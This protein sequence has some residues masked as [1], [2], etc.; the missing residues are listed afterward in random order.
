LQISER[1]NEPRGTRSKLRAQE[2]L[3]KSIYLSNPSL[4]IYI[5]Q[6]I[7]FVHCRYE[8]IVAKEIAPQRVRIKFPF[9][10]INTYYTGKTFLTK[11]VALNFFHLTK[12]GLEFIF[13]TAADQYAPKL[14]P[15]VTCPQH[16][17][18]SKFATKFWR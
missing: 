5:H 13:S 16:R 1:R 2:L 8:N 10:F 11:F 4:L 14:N 17:I 6:W 3:G 18:S 9:I 15:S 7:F 12:S